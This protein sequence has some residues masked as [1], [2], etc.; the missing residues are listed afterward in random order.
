MEDEGM[1]EKGTDLIQLEMM[2]KRGREKREAKSLVRQLKET[3][4]LSLGTQPWREKKSQL[5]HDWELVEDPVVWLQCPLGVCPSQVI[6]PSLLELPEDLDCH[7]SAPLFKGLPEVLGTSDDTSPPTLLPVDIENW[8]QSIPAP[9]IGA[10]Q[11][12]VALL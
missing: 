11:K 3:R 4:L 12:S 7:N 8:P 1:E 2:V 9:D 10:I 6:T 5:A